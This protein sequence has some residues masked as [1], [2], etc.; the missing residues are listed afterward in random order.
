LL[1]NRTY[2]SGLA[3]AVVF[4]GVAAGQALLVSMYMQTCEPFGGVRY[5]PPTAGQQIPPPS[6]RR[7]I[8]AG[9]EADEAEGRQGPG[10]GCEW[11]GGESCP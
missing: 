1:R 4:F 7:P 10:D 5:P 9:A 3:I 6:G 11:L 2:V 8:M